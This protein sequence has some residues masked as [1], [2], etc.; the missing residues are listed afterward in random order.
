M[1]PEDWRN[2]GL[3]DD[4]FKMIVEILGREPNYVELGM[5][6]VM[7]SEH[8]SY[9]NSKDTL[10]TFPTEGERVLQGPGENAGIVDIGDGLAV[11]FKIESHNHPSA[12]EPYQGAATGVGGIIRDIFTMGARPIASLNSLRFGTLDDAHVRYILD[13]VVAGIAGYGNCIGIPT[14]A[15]EVYFDPSYQ[16]NPLVNAMCVGLLETDKIKLGKATGIGNP[17]ILV[18]A[19][20]GRDGM[21]GVTFASEE[22]SEASE[23]K[24]PAVQVGDPFME[25]LLLEACLELINND[26]VVG[27]QDLGG[28][29]LT[30]ATSE[31]ASRGNSGLEIVLDRVPC[32]EEGMTPYEIMISESQERM[33]MVVTP[34]KEE[35]VH[36]TFKRWGLTSTTIGFVTSDGILRVH[37]GGKVVAEVPAHSLAEDAPVYCPAY[38]EPAYLQTTAK[39]DLQTLPDVEDANQVLLQLLA[40]P[41]IASKEWVWQQYDYMV[42]TSTVVLPGADA[43]VLR[44]RGTNKGLAMSTDCN[45]RYAYLDPYVGG[46]IAVAEAARN[47]VCS[48]GEPL[49]ITNCLNFGNPEEPEI[50]WQFRQAVAGMGE[51]CRA[52]NT[53]VTGG[54]VSFYNETN[55]EAIYP[56]PVVGMVG[57]LDDVKQHCTPAFKAAGDVVVLLGDTYNELGGSEYL[58]AIHQRVQG[59]PPALDMKK[60]KTLQKVV[61]AAIKQGLVNSAHDLSE[62]GLAVA[63]AECGFANG[64]GATIAL[65]ANGLRLDSLLFGESQS[66]VLISVSPENLSTL[67]ELAAQN[68]V[69][70]AELGQTGGTNM[71]VAVDGLTQLKLPLRQLKKAW[72]EAIPCAMK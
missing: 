64:I 20:T 71:E 39:L 65:T 49:A 10:R 7:W 2:M 42:R 29:G 14:V 70:A 52:L 45:A 34:E 53:P 48:G 9:K 5:Y 36:A 66:R 6:S 22:L 26:D 50:F 67:L 51:A 33:L 19:R 44:I 40:A 1:R 60:E 31:M 54:N 21:H 61:L 30:C 46:K 16:G 37:Q 38:Q 32:R 62:G 15:G 4:E 12:I 43:A 59:Q 47:V 56:T 35:K 69:S 63:L 3:K 28:A 24:R 57:L 68:G 18:G 23:E 58:A 8:C 55:G 11:C 13:G 17:V 72:Q 41:N 27:I 25:K